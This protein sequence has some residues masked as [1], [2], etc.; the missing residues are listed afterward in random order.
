MTEVRANTSNDEASLLDI[1]ITLNIWKKTIF[2]CTA[3]TVLV[4]FLFAVLSQ[5]LYRA[6]VTLN[7]VLEEGSSLSSAASQLG[8]V[9]ALAG[10]DLGGGSSNR[11]EYIAILKSRDLGNMF[12]ENL[13]LKPHLFPERWDT[14]DAKWKGKSG[15]KTGLIAFISRLLARLSGD[16]GWTEDIDAVPSDWEAYKEFDENIRSVSEDNKTGIVRVSFEFRNPQRVAEW[17]N[18]YIEL[19]NNEIR[20]RTVEETSKAIAYLSER[21]EETTVAGVRETIYG[22]IETQL[23]KVMLANVRSEYAFKVIDKAIV[24]DKKS[25]PQRGL[26]VI[27]SL[28]LGLVLGIIVSLILESNR[29]GAWRRAENTSIQNA[30]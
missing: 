18:R 2:I 7:P 22:L 9:A 6:S 4:G 16:E 3:A 12:I 14:S 25:S 19:A 20:E 29:N 17:A 24:P 21:A 13:D 10:I 15:K 11:E 30:K 8:G 5:P 1:L 26:T 27:V 28:V 23:E